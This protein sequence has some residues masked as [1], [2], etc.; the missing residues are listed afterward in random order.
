MDTLFLNPYYSYSVSHQRKLSLTNEIYQKYSL[1][2][3]VQCSQW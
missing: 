3:T 1:K 2:Y